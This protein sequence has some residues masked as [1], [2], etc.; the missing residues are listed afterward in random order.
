MRRWAMVAWVVGVSLDVCAAAAMPADSL[1]AALRRTQTMGD[2]ATAVTAGGDSLTI[3]VEDVYAD[4]VAVRR[5]LG[6]LYEQPAVYALTDLR[7]VVP[8]TPAGTIAAPGHHLSLRSAMGLELLIPG[9]GYLYVGD[10]GTAL[11]LAGLAGLAAGTA[12]L[13]GQDGA[14][15]WV[16]AMAWIKVASLLHLRDEVRAR[17]GALEGDTPRRGGGPTVPPGSY[18][19]SL[20]LHVP[21]SA[22]RPLAGLGVSARF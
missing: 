19:R 4:S 13:T 16:P 12:V 2:W 10:T 11:T 6:P 1:V 21:A 7:L 5:R 20:S 9:A 22:G 17:N 14:A 18:L 8:W 15:G 3:L